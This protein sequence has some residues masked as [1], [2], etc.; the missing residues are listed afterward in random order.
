MTTHTEHTR[1]LAAVMFVDIVGYTA[2]MQEDEQRAILLR[3]RQR[4][5]L[6]E[7]VQHHQG[8]IRQYYGDG[9]LIIFH[10]A[11]KAV[12]CAVDIQYDLKQ[13]PRVPVRIGI[14]MGDIISDTEGVYGD[15]VNVAA[16]VEAL[17]FS[18]GILISEKVNDEITN[19]PDLKTLMVGRFQLKNVKSP[20]KLYAVRDYSFSISNGEM[21]LKLQQNTSGSVVME[22]IKPYIENV[23]AGLIN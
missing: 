8:V 19:H 2:L 7:K 13:K 5:V 17:S 22:L 11:Y 21:A 1:F 23:N 10:S 14:H 4:R 16:R 18:G 20:M 3:S 12:Q 9:A 6:E 15:A